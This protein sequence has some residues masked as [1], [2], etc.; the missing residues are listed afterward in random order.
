M[1]KAVFIDKDGTLIKDVPYNVN[2]ELIFLNDNIAEV[3]SILRDNGY[4]LILVSNQ[5]GIAKGFFSKEE[6]MIASSK[7]IEL[8]AEESAYLDAYY[9]CPHHPEGTM[10]EFSVSCSCRKPAP[11]MLLMAAREHNIDLSQSW[12]IGDILD[13]ME[14]GKRAGCKTIFYNNGNETAWEMNAF[15]KPDYVISDLLEAAGIIYGKQEYSV[16]NF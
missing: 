4:L 14:A 3:L 7:I 12:M 1:N 9:Y 10:P 6:L 2:P 15:R 11:G 13:D 8:L 5:A 16:G